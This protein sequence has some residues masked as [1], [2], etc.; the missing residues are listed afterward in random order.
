MWLFVINKLKAL[1]KGHYLLKKKINHKNTMKIA[2]YFPKISV[3]LAELFLCHVNTVCTLTE[4][5]YT[6][7]VLGYDVVIYKIKEHGK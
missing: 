5:F 1:C 3:C 7:Q 6:V 4:Y 2:T